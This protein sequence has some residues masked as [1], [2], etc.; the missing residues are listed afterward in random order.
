MATKILSATVTAVKIGQLEIDGLMFDSG[1]YGISIPQANALIS[2]SASKNTAS[3]DLKRLL[4]DA[5]SPSKAKVKGLKQLINTLSLLEL[6]KLL[7]EL[8]LIG[9]QQAIAITRSLV[10]LSLSQLFADAFGQK[11]AVDDRQAYLTA[12]LQG[13]V[14][15]R[16]LTDAIKS[17]LDRHENL[18]QNYRTF[19]YATASD[20]INIALFGKTSKDLCDEKRCHRHELR[21]CFDDSQLVEIRSREDF[22][23]KLIDKHNTEPLAAIEEAITFFE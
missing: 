20:R 15:R 8:A 17:Y 2:F 22:A 18:S 7:F 6:E 5:F 12:R 4:G 3:R 9:N 1:D 16:L 19:I 23:A 21:D 13:K 14:K 11:F 10:G